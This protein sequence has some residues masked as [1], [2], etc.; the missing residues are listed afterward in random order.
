MEYEPC[1]AWYETDIKFLL[2]DINGRQ[3]C[4]SEDNI[5]MDLRDIN[6]QDVE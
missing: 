2:E 4:R 1:T 6:Y 5:K 3:R